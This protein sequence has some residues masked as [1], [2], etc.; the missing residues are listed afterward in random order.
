[1]ELVIGGA[2]QGKLT[3]AMAAYGIA[4]EEVCDLAHGDPQE[5]FRC[6]THLEALTLR[7]DA[8]ER[9]LPLL[10]GGVVVCREIGC[11]VVPTEPEQ[12]QWRER[13]GAFLQRLA[14][15]ACHVTRVFCGLAEALK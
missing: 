10:S 8:P 5:G 1:M 2:Y 3:W 4:P 6:Y 12:R 9:W 13:H 15:D 11:G 7:D 14:R